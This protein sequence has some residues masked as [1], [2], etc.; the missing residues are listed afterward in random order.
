MRSQKSARSLADHRH[1]YARRTMMRNGMDYVSAHTFFG[2]RIEII[3]REAPIFSCRSAPQAKPSSYMR[4]RRRK[5]VMD[6]LRHP[7]SSPILRAGV[8]HPAQERTLK[9]SL[10]PPGTWA[11]LPWRSGT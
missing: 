4:P 10:R 9:I 8:K 2:S 3:Q 1:E 11:S 6:Y 7:V 5:G